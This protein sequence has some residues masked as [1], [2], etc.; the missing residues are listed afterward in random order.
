[1]HGP[2]NIKFKNFWDS[3]FK[4]RV[5]VIKLGHYY[6]WRWPWTL[7]K[8]VSCYIVFRNNYLETSDS[9]LIKDL[10]EHGKLIDDH[11]WNREKISAYHLPFFESK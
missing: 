4:C 10:Q 1:M 9:F 11:T 2:Y 3:M 8:E 5:Y 7:I 6:R